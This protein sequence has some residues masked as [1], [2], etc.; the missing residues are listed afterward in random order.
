[1][2]ILE[3]DG[4]LRALGSELAKFIKYNSAERLT[5][6]S[7][8]A[9]I[10]DLAVDHP[11]LNAP[12]KDL[13]SRQS[14]RSLIPHAT[15]GGG[16]IQRD[17]LIQEISRVYHPAV[18]IEIEHVLNGYLE[19]SGGVASQLSQNN[20]IHDK[21]LNA[22]AEGDKASV[23]FKPPIAS[24]SPN[25][26]NIQRQHSSVSQSYF[27]NALEIAK[28]LVGV[29][30]ESASVN[31]SGKGLLNYVLRDS[32]GNDL[33]RISLA[34]LEAKL[35]SAQSAIINQHALT[36]QLNLANS[37]DPMFIKAVVLARCMGNAHLD[38]ASAQTSSKGIVNYIIRDEM[39]N[40][41]AKVPLSMLQNS[42]K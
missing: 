13:V 20:F 17:A 35:R 3:S 12:L 28:K 14:F 9:V 42:F 22:K 40:T 31:T 18:L 11:D 27:A 16:A 33:A 32:S 39:S 5:S 21:S 34:M 29:N 23:G 30:L 41:L 36:S 26:G 7:L 24:S 38:E 1:M 25:G 15:S 10:A 2:S 19:S 6:A 8:Q 4:N 37:C